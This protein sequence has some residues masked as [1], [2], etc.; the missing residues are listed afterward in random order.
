MLELYHGGTSVCSAKVRVG[1]AEKGLEWKGH[2]IDLQ[3]GEQFEPDYLA[4]N[5]NGVVPTLLDDGYIVTESS[6]IL[7]YVDSLSSSNTLMPESLR[8]QTRARLWLLRCLDIH[9]AI[10]TMTFATV[11][12]QQ[13]VSSK[14]PE[15][16]AASIAKMPNPRA[17]AKRADL[18]EK[19]LD[20]AHV[21]ADFF[22]LR[23]VFMD[24]QDALAQGP[25][26][27]GD[28]YSIVDAA[29]IAYIDRLDRLGMSGLW[30][31][32]YPGVGKWLSASRQRPSYETAIG[33]YASPEA[34]QKMRDAGA[35]QWPEVAERWDAFIN[36]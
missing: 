18:F 12:R 15:E 22:V 20:S 27:N 33:A 24:M 26:M 9:A 21:V 16:I 14:T 25:W 19:G 11:N 2:L 10:N 5:P 23:K 32:R 7:E 8:G 17:A 29:I 30:E 36:G 13:I 6:I 28:R 35:S 31:E 34:A 3:K 4:L 1:L